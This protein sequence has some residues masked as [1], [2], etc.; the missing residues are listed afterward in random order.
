MIPFRTYLRWDIVDI[1]WFEGRS[2]SHHIG[3]TALLPTAKIN[4]K[5]NLVTILL[6][7]HKI[8]IERDATYSNRSR[9]SARVDDE[10]LK[11]MDCV[12]LFLMCED[13][14]FPKKFA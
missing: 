5:E 10:A 6:K 12:V 1:V 4:I 8:I 14:V 11:K 7:V 2:S 9:L 13:F 3:P